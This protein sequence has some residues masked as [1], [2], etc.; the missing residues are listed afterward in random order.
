MREVSYPISVYQQGQGRT[1]RHAHFIEG[2]K[3]GSYC[4]IAMQYND[5]ARREHIHLCK[6]HSH[7]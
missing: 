2:E 3:D 6:Q 5:K 7:D 4:E 1:A